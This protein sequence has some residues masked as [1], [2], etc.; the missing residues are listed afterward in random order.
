[1]IVHPDRNTPWGCYR[2]LTEEAMKKR[3]TKKDIH[4]QT[5]PA[6]NDPLQVSLRDGGN[7]GCMS[8][9]AR[10]PVKANKSANHPITKC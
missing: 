6:I 4:R 3:A 8:E 1:M 9:R 10:L 2:N 7:I 5:T